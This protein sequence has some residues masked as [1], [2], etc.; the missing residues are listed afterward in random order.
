MARAPL[1]QVSRHLEG[2]YRGRNQGGETARMPLCPSIMVPRTSRVVAPTRASR[3]AA[4]DSTWWRTHSAAARVLPAPRPMRSSQA[5]QPPAGGRWASRARGCLRHSPAARPQGQPGAY[6]SHKDR[7][8]W[9]WARGPRRA[10]ARAM[11]RAVR[12]RPGM[13]APPRRMAGRRWP[14]PVP[15]RGRVPSRWRR[16]GAD[17]RPGRG[18]SRWRRSWRRS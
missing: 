9:A 15:G 18:A 16:R 4:P 1:G 10:S 12:V 14:I 6:Q 8:A 13:I 17:A 7:S 5:R 3:L 11:R 2:S